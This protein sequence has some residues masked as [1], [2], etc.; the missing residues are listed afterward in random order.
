MARIFLLDGGCEGCGGW[1][2]VIEGERGWWKVVEG[3]RGY[4]GCGGIRLMFEE[5]I[6]LKFGVRS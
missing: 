5:K 6:D 1:W 2:R 3:C 4:E